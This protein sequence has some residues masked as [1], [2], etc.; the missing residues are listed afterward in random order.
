MIDKMKL[1]A[2]VEERLGYYVYAL[3]NPIDKKVFYVGKGVG[4]RV[5]AH[6]NGV[7]DAEDVPET[8]KI[9]TIKSI[10]EAGESVESFIIQHGLASDNHAFQT[11]SAVYG[12]LKLLEE[13]PGHNLFSLT[14]IIQPPTFEDQGLMSV[15]D[16]LA[17]YGE[18]ADGML[19][20]HN[21]IFVKPAQL[22]RKGMPSEELWEYTRG[23]WK[24]S[25]TR[26]RDV[27]YVFSV[28]NFVIR[29]VW[30]VQASDWREQGRGDRG[31][32]DILNQRAKGGGKKPRL[33]FDSCVD[34][35]ES[36]F[37]QL[38][39]KSVLHAYRE[40][41]GKRP[42]VVY[43]DDKKVKALASDAKRREPFWNVNLKS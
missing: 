13:Q 38:I 33:G 25:E 9:Q 28:P 12:V 19:I 11:E 20:P 42:N 14:N 30:E 1:T 4:S 31:W 21:S 22:W 16:V 41:Q 7:I 10:H 35:S 3:R 6:A 39:N 17:L 24:M 15:N 43:L 36:K 27:R 5:L 2:Y 37:S 34:V 26:I 32:D 23:W 40:G 8:M 29:A 18:P